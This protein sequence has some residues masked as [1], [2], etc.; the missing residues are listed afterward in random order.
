MNCSQRF[1]RFSM[2]DDRGNISLRRSLCDCPDVD[3]GF[4]ECTKK[5]SSHTELIDHAVAYHG[6]DAT[7]LGQIH[8]L[9]LSTLHLDEERF[10]NRLLRE[11]CVD[12]RHGEADRMLGARLRDH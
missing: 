10:F 5:L 3:A 12:T 6:N 4:S 2:F 8:C 7:T 11:L 1:R 9:N